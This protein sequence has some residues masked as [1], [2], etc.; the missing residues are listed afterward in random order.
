[1]KELNIIKKDEKLLIDTKRKISKTDNLILKYNNENYIIKNK[2]SPCLYCDF[3]NYN[4]KNKENPCIE[5]CSQILGPEK[6]LKKTE[7]FEI[8]FKKD[9]KG[10]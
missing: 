8:L 3:L 7:I 2:Q 5:N 10:E 9:K 1:M 4:E 6:Y